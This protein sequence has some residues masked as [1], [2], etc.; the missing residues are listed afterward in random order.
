MD[1]PANE[2]R[3]ELLRIL[4]SLERDGLIVS[5][6]GADGQIWWGAT[7]KKLHRS[8]DRP[9]STDRVS[10]RKAADRGTTPTTDAGLAAL[11]RLHAVYNWSC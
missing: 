9:K 2:W 5:W 11:L 7:G 1:A 4:R 3:R 10:V 6:M 8:G